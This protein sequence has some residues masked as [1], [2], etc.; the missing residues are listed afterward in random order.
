MSS[1]PSSSDTP[2]ARRRSS[3]RALAGAAFAL[4]LSFVG[5]AACGSGDATP[6]DPG[7]PPSARELFLSNCARCHGRSGEGSF[8]AP[9]LAGVEQHWDV[10]RLQRYLRDPDKVIAEDERLEK[11]G[12]KYGTRMP[13]F[14]HL[15]P[16]ER[17]A[18]AQW[19]LDGR[20]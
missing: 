14:Q 13:T 8:M 19:V 5:L 15:T 6:Q 10:E 2:R 12:R 4:G 9:T 7:A 3:A 17:R 16:D 20:P 18:L 1:A 11:Q